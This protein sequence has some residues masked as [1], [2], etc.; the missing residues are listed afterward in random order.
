MLYYAG[1]PTPDISEKNFES[2]IECT[3]LAGGPDAKTWVTAR[4]FGFRKTQRVWAAHPTIHAALQPAVDRFKDTE[5]RIGALI[6]KAVAA[7]SRPCSSGM[8][9]KRSSRRKSADVIGSMRK[10]GCSNSADDVW[11]VS[12][13]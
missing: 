5:V 2:T 12:L 11:F 7:I 8:A 1:G 13:R 4:P 10:G 3:L 9:L 6:R